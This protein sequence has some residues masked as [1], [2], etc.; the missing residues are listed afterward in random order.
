MMHHHGTQFEGPPEYLDK[1][2]GI[3]R[4]RYDVGITGHD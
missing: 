3:E 1:L 2:G 4:R